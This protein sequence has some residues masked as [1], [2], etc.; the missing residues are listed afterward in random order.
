MSG[1]EHHRR[2][3]EAF[4]AAAVLDPKARAEWLASLRAAEPEIARD[5]EA[6]LA[7]DARDSSFLDTPALVDVRVLADAPAVAGE[8][9]GRF[10]AGTIVA[11]RYR[12]VA[13]LGRGGM[14]EVYRAEDLRLDQ[15]V[16]LKFLPERLAA[17]PTAR[18]R[19][20]QEVRSAREVSHPHVCRV[21]DLGEDRGR[22]FLSMEL[23]DG[24]DL[25]ALLRRI[26]HLPAA[27]AVEV[28]RQLCGGLTAIH[29]AGLLHRDLKPANVMLDGRGR[30]RITDL[31]I[32]GLAQA[33]GGTGPAG[34]PAYMAPE[35]LLGAKASPQSDVYALGLVLY[36]LFTGGR[37]FPGT[38]MDELLRR[39][40]TSP[41][42][43]TDVLP[44]LDPR[45]ERVLL[46]CLEADPAARPRSAL[47]VLA[48][49]PGGD[50]LAEA[51]ALGQTPPPELVAA[52]RVEDGIGRRGAI[53]CLLGIVGCLVGFAALGGSAGGLLQ[54]VPFEK[55]PAELA[56]AADGFLSS[57]GY[58]GRGQHVAYSL[59]HDFELLDAFAARRDDRLAAA[60][61]SGHGAVHLWYRRSPRPLIADRLGFSSRVGS[62]NPP[63]DRP[64]MVGVEVDTLGRLIHLWAVPERE[65]VQKPARSA[66]WP[67]LLAAAGLDP[68]RL[69][70]AR[71][72]LTPPSP[73]DEAT[74]WEGTF[75]DL[76]RVQ[77]RVEAAA[78]RGRP[79]S[80]EL[81][82]PWRH[83]GESWVAY[84]TSGAEAVAL[85]V[86]AAG[87]LL[88]RRNVRRGRGDRRGAWRLGGATAACS[89]VIMLSRGGLASTLMQ[90]WSRAAAAVLVGI[91]TGCLY[92]AVEPYVRRRW[93]NRLVS[94]ARLLAGRWR[95]P[96]VGRDLL[97]GL[98]AGAGTAVA[99]QLVV[100][101]IDRPSAD[102][103]LAL[104][105]GTSQLVGAVSNGIAVGIVGAPALAF[106][107]TL[108]RALLR[109]EALAA[110]AAVAVGALPPMLA[111]GWDLELGAKLLFAG[112]AA[113]LLFLRAGMLAAATFLGVVDLLGRL[114]LTL[115]P[116]RWYFGV[117]C[118]A[119]LVLLAVALVACRNA[120][121]GEPLFRGD[122]LE[123]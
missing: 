54:R 1:V 65:E 123:A 122:P 16:A 109:H 93:P 48:A 21:H 75:A 111:S 40:E 41:T 42:P 69:R 107:L 87:F 88:A 85:A 18:Q 92:L 24:E 28:A 52:A 99:I 71:P 80:F 36:E 51:L 15:P 4:H 43:P 82:W 9:A 63:R 11:D 112:G 12:V 53:L 6:L 14:G 31:G 10:V 58:E 79:V 76:P 114:A 74:A 50:P 81:A 25:G 17:D 8:A 120:L 33:P 34:T 26:G 89:L 78:L 56:R 101:A 59:H 66:D 35:Q 97:V 39:G 100:R 106:L 29:A 105:L 90:A 45:I 116:G 96:L 94:W 38:T 5:L 2:L 84:G 64:G 121:G 118:A 72:R 86:A 30:A 27:K 83:R 19:L 108:L 7:A 95:D 32:A 62:I 20:H 73:F 37:A 23:I 44:G 110:A 102:L 22:T 55:S 103:E 113:A 46:A 60:F 117:S 98:F 61:T 67:A 47:S 68:R 77:V 104:L 70:P 119:L 13:F 3:R 115:D 49:L 91:V 57:F